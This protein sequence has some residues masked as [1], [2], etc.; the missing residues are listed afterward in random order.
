MK[1]SELSFKGTPK[2][3]LIADPEQSFIY[4][5]GLYH[6]DILKFKCANDVIKSVEAYDPSSKLTEPQKEF[7][8]KHSNKEV[9]CYICH[10]HEDYPDIFVY[11]DNNIAFQVDCFV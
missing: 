6:C 3:A 7:I 1:Y 5:Y 10:M 2:S 4:K 9:L 11:G 8:L